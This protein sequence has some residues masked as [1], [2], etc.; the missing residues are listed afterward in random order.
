[1]KPK[2]GA[3]KDFVTY[4]QDLLQK[5]FSEPVLKP[6]LT[7]SQ[8]EDKTVQ[9]YTPR[10]PIKGGALA[11]DH[12]P[13]GLPGGKGDSG[14]KSVSDFTDRASAL[15]DHPKFY[16]GQLSA[17]KGAKSSSNSIGARVSEKESLYLEKGTPGTVVVDWFEATLMGD[18]IQLWDAVP[19]DTD[20]IE[21][22]QG[23]HLMRHRYDNGEAK[24]TKHY[25]SVWTIICEGEEIATL[26]VGQ[27]GSQSQFG[28]MASLAVLNEQLYHAGWTDAI[29]EFLF[30][31]NLRIR[32][33]TRLD[34][35]LDSAKD[36]TQSVHDLLL[37]SQYEKVGKVSIAPHAVIEGAKW[38]GLKIGSMKSDMY[39]SVY[40]KTQELKKQDGK[41]DYIRDHWK[42]NGLNTDSDISRFEIRMK[43]KRLKLIDEWG[44]NPD[45]S[46]LEDAR[47]LASLMRTAVNGWLQF[48]YIGNDTNKARRAQKEQ[49]GKLIDWKGMKGDLLDRMP[50]RITQGD[51]W[52][53]RTTVRGMLHSLIVLDDPTVS[54]DLI[55]QFAKHGDQLEWYEEK[56]EHLIEK[57]E[58]ERSR[59]DRMQSLCMN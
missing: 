14:A 25:R 44:H 38:Q 26:K 41:K 22:G 20:E 2:I 27:R 34:L 19:N 5:A 23:F 13:E 30:S 6:G 24:T 52:K 36:L 37:S 33:V 3:S 7:S 50:K 11:L 8:L 39:G 21:V 16:W 45:I 55:Y 48:K 18:I 59:R 42:L 35:A 28:N 9:F 53:R 32:T 29:T 1:M 43:W 10:L 51:I 17:D 54:W 57:Y 4:R 15:V 31:S 49:A 12:R 40:N 47:Y 46:S 56:R 58:R